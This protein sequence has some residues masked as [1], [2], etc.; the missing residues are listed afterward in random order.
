MKYR[1]TGEP[2]LILALANSVV[3]LIAGVIPAFTPTEAGAINAAAAA[4]LTLVAAWSTRP[5]PVTLAIGAFNT[6]VACAVAFWPALHFT[7][8]QVGLVDA[9][10]AAVFG[11]LLRLHVSPVGKSKPAPAPPAA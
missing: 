8:S 9:V 3:A 4:I 6:L 2:A 10:I 1:L 7:Q 11:V 5:F